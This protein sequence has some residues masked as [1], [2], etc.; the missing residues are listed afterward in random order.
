MTFT[1]QQIQNWRAYEKVRATGQWN[2]FDRAAVQAT[3]LSRDGFLFAI[4]NY[5]AL[6][7]QAETQKEPQNVH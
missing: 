5:S 4:E 1:T 7:E 2:M 6:A 3:G